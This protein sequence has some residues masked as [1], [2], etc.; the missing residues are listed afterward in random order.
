ERDVIDEGGRRCAQELARLRTRKMPDGAVLA[1]PPALACLVD[2]DA[3]LEE[4]IDAAKLAPHADRPG[5]RSRADSQHALDLI[6][7]LD[8]L[9]AVPVELVDEGHDGRVA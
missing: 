4:V 7:Q 6:E 1:N 8:R 3:I 2:V 5:D 9:S